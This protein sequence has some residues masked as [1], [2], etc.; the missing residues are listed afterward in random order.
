MLE[1][2]WFY[3]LKLSKINW[4]V[5]DTPLIPALERQRQLDLSEFED[6]QGYIR[7]PC[8][9]KKNMKKKKTKL[10]KIPVVWR[11]FF[12]VKVVCQQ[13]LMAT[14]TCWGSLTKWHRQRPAE[15][16]LCVQVLSKKL[17]WRIKVSTM[18]SMSVPIWYSWRLGKACASSSFRVGCLCLCRPKGIWRKYTF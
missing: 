12:T 9:R 14:D 7:K 3:V 1:Y 13:L 15:L 2:L 18:L 17:A 16:R 5:V 11:L 10:S 6:S 4:V 8:L